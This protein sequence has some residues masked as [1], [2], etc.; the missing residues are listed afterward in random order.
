MSQNCK[1]LI[2]EDELI[3]R[4]ALR[5]IIG[6]KADQFCIVGEASNGKDAQILIEKER[7]HV[8]IC[9]IVMPVMDG[10]ELTKYIRLK[11]PN[12]Y[13]IILSSHGNFDYVRSTFQYGVFE[14][15]LK[16]QLEP[17]QL[18]N[19][20][21][22]A[23][24][25]LNL[26][27][28]EED[29]KAKDFKTEGIL[30]Q[31]LN[32]GNL[33]TSEED[34]KKQYAYPYFY[35][36]AC[37]L[38]KIE[39]YRKSKEHFYYEAL[40]EM[41]ESYFKNIPQEHALTADGVVVILLNLKETMETEWRIKIEQIGCNMEEQIP[42]VRLA[43]SGMFL[44]GVQI[45]EKIKAV[46]K[47]LDLQFYMNENQIVFDD[48]NYK[49][50]N[51]VAFNYKEYREKINRGSYEDAFKILQ[52]FINNV[53][54]TSGIKEQELKK[55]VENTIYN[56]FNTLE[57]LAFNIEAIKDSKLEILNKI[58]KTKSIQ[59][60]RDYVN[61][62]I[63]TMTNV[64]RSQDKSEHLMIAQMYSYIDT[65][66]SEPIT[67]NDL[68]GIFHMS[69]SYLS[70]YFSTTSNKGFNE[71]LNE[72]RINKAKQLLKH[73]NISISDIGEKVGYADQ[74]YFSKVFKKMTQCSPSE[75]RRGALK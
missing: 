40:V 7:P 26:T 25:G 29:T 67:L 30:A 35:L 33:L 39:G 13:I 57:E 8:V 73:S 45:P 59:Q 37:N 17:E 20:L 69:Y 36:I 55:I 18:L 51:K 64:L 5:Y 72:V 68:A 60:L 9:D 75:Y 24:V 15:I 43:V 12:I 16:P 61:K 11:Y 58:V 48:V 65:H 31:A 54:G 66:Y 74:S 34:I 38:E 27:F 1:V 56:T 63:D 49:L 70:T 3:T 71:Y 19:I 2:V 62:I 21:H 6:L 53:N 23:A 14:Y 28:C 44:K 47:L 42:G 46:I 52:D 41:A 50:F 32:G 10:I 4:Q 22:K